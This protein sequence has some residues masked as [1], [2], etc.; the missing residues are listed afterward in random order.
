MPKSLKQEPRPL[1]E[2]PNL[3]H[4]RDEAKALVKTGAALSLSAAQLQ[5]AR[6]YGFASWPRLKAHVDAIEAAQREFAELKLAIDGNDLERVKALTLEGYAHQ[7][8]PF[9]QVVEALQPPRN[10]FRRRLLPTSVA[11]QF[12]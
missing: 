8:V 1:P 9:E 12:A 2:R 5:I 7:D 11:Q 6:L 3:R 10:M 4:L